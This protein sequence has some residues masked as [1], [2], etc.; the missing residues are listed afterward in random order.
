MNGTKIIK[1]SSYGLLIMF[2]GVVLYIMSQYSYLLFHSVAEL[3]SV[4]IAFGIFMF[5]LNTRKLGKNSYLN[6]L[7]VAYFFIGSFDLLHTLSYKGMGIFLNYDSNLP[8]QL[9][10][11][12][13]YM[14]SI[15]L[16]LAVAFIGRT[17]NFGRTFSIYLIISLVLLLLIFTEQGI[18]VSYIEEKGLTLFKIVS[19]Y[20]ISL[21]FLCSLLLIQ[22]EKKRFS[23]KIYNLI[24]VSIVLSIFA[25]LAFTLYVSV[26]GFSNLVGHYLKIGSYYCVYKAIIGSGLVQPYTLLFKELKEK[27][28]DLTK[29]RDDLLEAQKQIKTLSGLMPIC[30]VCKKIR[31]DSGYWNHLE[32][33]IESNSDAIFS[34]G[35]CPDCAKKTYGDQPWFDEEDL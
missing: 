12:A 21:I 20:I 34:H 4:I 26:F 10:I 32:M 28:K 1:F 33:F 8:V 11:S 9:W 23:A 16:C 6:L 2:I 3:F 25:E 24:R 13:R 30:A 27:E 7:G 18:P 14:E 22:K 19:E 5:A 31:D 29:E 15:T 35:I 17:I